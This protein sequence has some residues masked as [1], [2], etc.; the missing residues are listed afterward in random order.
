[1]IDKNDVSDEQID[2]AYGYLSEY[3]EKNN[4]DLIDFVSNP[5]N[6]DMASEYIHKQLNFALRLVLRPKIIAS[7]IKNNHE[8]IIEKA[9]QKHI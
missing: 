7:L 8:W 3:C 9:R 6:I 5:E 4:L 2:M 1:M